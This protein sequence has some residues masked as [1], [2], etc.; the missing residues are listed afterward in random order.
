M[1]NRTGKCVTKE[2]HRHIHNS[3]R[4][5]KGFTLTEVLIVIAI[6][7]LFVGIT[8]MNL[9]DGG[10]SRMADEEAMRM[11]AL[12][13]LAQE[14]A[15]LNAK[16]I[17][18]ELTQDG[19]VFVELYENKWQPM[20]E[21]VFRKRKLKAGI[22]LGL[23]VESL[24]ADLQKPQDNDEESD[25]SLDKQ[26]VIRIYFLS[27]GEMTPFIMKLKSEY[28]DK[29]YELVGKASGELEIHRPDN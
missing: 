6:I 24:E 11:K 27:S 21:S 8:T 29:P 10:L 20:Q 1:N 14:E 19:Y 22:E 13:K 17:A 9:G 26:E 5:R 4:N 23:T 12:I 28:M 7:G 15:I 18:L 16:E 3:Q 25:L 2:C